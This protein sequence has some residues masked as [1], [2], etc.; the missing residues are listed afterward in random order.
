MATKIT[1]GSAVNAASNP[2]DEL[3]SEVQE[4]I[5]EDSKKKAKA[6][7][8]NLLEQ[9]IKTERILHNIDRQIEDLKLQISQ[10]LG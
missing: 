8:K 5:N 1:K 10:E 2:I 6:K 9:K 7:I 4:E 3:F